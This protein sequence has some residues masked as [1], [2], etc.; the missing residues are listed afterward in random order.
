MTN[1][2][3]SS[4][5]SSTSSPW[6]KSGRD[7]SRY[8]VSDKAMTAMPSKTSVLHLPDAWFIAC[9][10]RALRDKPI[11]FTLQG[12]PLVLFRGAEGKPAALLDRCPHRNAPLSLGKVVNGELQC[13]YHGWRFDGAGFCRACI[14]ACCASIRVRTSPRRA[15]DRPTT[16]RCA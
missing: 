1:S 11:S 3:M 14:A 9:E 5:T 13:G 7:R 15:R 12:T 16:L 6:V 10:A 4:V 8:I 2:Q